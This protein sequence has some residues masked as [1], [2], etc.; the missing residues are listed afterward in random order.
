MRSSGRPLV[1]LEVELRRWKCCR[2]RK[3]DLAERLA[4]R[5]ESESSKVNEMSERNA[6]FVRLQN[7]T[8]FSSFPPFPP[9]PSLEIQERR[10]GKRT[11]CLVFSTSNPIPVLT[12]SSIET[13][14]MSLMPSVGRRFLS[15]R[16]ESEEAPAGA[17]MS[18]GEDSSG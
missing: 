11:H 9:N 8:S 16:T 7:R 2:C 17:R 15:T 12:S 18:D 6:T 5:N 14:L 3:M 1:P 10:N 13:W 4:C